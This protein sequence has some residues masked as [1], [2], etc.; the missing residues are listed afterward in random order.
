MQRHDVFLTTL[1]YDFNFLFRYWLSVGAQPS[2]PVQRLLF[3]AGLLPPPPILALL[4]KGGR[5]EERPV[6]PLNGRPI[7]PSEDIE[8]ISEIKGDSTSS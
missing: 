2:D 7:A 8:E 3:R 5:S 6:D 4:R 1:P